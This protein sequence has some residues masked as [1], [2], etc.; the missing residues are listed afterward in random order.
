MDAAGIRCSHG[1]LIERPP[2]TLSTQ[3]SS[4]KTW[5]T[6]SPSLTWPYVSRVLSRSVSILHPS[7]LFLS[8]LCKGSYCYSTT[9]R[10]CRCVGEPEW[11]GRS[12]AGAVWMRTDEGDSIDKRVKEMRKERED[13]FLFF[14]GSFPPSVMF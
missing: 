4:K 10:N 13:P 12:S 7:K 2:P 9:M 3:G 1:G 8:S 14:Q 6:L 5:R 11:G